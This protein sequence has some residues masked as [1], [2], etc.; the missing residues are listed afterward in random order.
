MSKRELIGLRIL[1]LLA[2]IVGLALLVSYQ[3]HSPTIRYLGTVV[4]SD[5][6]RYC[7]FVC[8]LSQPN[9]SIRSAEAFGYSIADCTKLKTSE[10]APAI[11][12]KYDAIVPRNI[13]FPYPYNDALPGGHTDVIYF[14]M[15]MG[16]ATGSII[17]FVAV[18][19][20]EQ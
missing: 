5:D 4:F 17:L 8:Y 19:A 20:K 9:V 2:F 3:F 7:E 6:E 15:I 18:E 14:L 1:C 10:P 16:G 12:V 13:S 11:W